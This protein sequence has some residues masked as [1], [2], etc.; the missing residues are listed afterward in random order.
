MPLL[1][2]QYRPLS[3]PNERNSP[4]GHPVVVE[5]PTDEV[6][7]GGVLF[8]LAP[9]PKPFP[10]PHDL[11]GYFQAKRAPPFGILAVKHTASSLL[12]FGEEMFFVGKRPVLD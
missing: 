11:V 9:S 8:G 12:G 7:D 6:L 4:L 1:H 10:N 2:F 3:G 5:S